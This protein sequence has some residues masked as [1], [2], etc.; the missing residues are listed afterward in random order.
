MNIRTDH[1]G[2]ETISFRG[3]KISELIPDDMKN[4]KSLEEFKRKFWYWTPPGCQCNICKFLSCSNRVHIRC[5]VMPQ[6]INGLEL[7]STNNGNYVFRFRKCHLSPFC[8][9]LIHNN[10]CISPYQIDTRKSLI[11][12]VYLHNVHWKFK[13]KKA[14]MC[15]YSRCR[16][17]R[18]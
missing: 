6:R 2:S 14:L 17:H 4:A 5:D 1:Y 12:L 3:P 8:G 10:K 16:M 9:D 13:T 7:F 18:R 15:L 11:R